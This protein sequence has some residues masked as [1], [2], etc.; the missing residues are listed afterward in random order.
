MIYKYFLPF[1]RSSC[2]FLKIS[3]WCTARMALKPVLTLY[4]LGLWRKWNPPP[5]PLQSLSC[6]HLCWTVP[7]KELLLLFHLFPGTTEGNQWTLANVSWKAF[8]AKSLFIS[9][10]SYL[11]AKRRQRHLSIFCS[12]SSFSFSSLLRHF[13]VLPALSGSSAKCSAPLAAGCCV[14]FGK[15]SPEQWLMITLICFTWVCSSGSSPWVG[16]S[17]TLLRSSRCFRCLYVLWEYPCFLSN[18]HRIPKS[19]RGQAVE[20]EA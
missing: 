18:G 17:V 15:R 4:P 1:G 6:L 11:A 8:L 20:S 14:I 5:P 7:A 2:Q 12:S 10:A 9:F 3:L 19:G 13:P 16:S